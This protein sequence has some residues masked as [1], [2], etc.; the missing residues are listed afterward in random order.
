[1]TLARVI[2]PNGVMCQPLVKFIKIHDLAQVPSYSRDGDAGMDLRC[3]ENFALNPGERKTI[4][5]GLRIKIE[6]GFEGQVRPRSGLAANYGI[7]VVNTPG[8]VDSNYTGELKIVLLNTSDEI[9]A[10]AAKDRIAQIVFAPVAQAIV[11]DVDDFEETTN[12]GTAGF[13]SSGLQ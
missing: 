10:F 8:T 3:V 13:G 7:T 6:K 5:T 2:E 9:V 12:R 11:M 1:M 4:T